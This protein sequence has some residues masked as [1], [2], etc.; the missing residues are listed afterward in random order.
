MHSLKMAALTAITTLGLGAASSVFANPIVNAGF[1]QFP[2]FTGYTTLGNTTIQAGNFHPPVEGALQAL[3]SNGAGDSTGGLNPVTGAQLES[4]LNLTAGT[5]TNAATFKAFTGSAIQQTFTALA[6]Q[7]L[8]LQ[9]DFLTNES[10][11]GRTGRNDTAF[12]TLKNGTNPATLAVLADTNSSLHAT[13]P[14]NDDSNFATSETGYLTY[15]TT[16][17]AGGTYTLGLGVINS[18]DGNVA[19][20]VMVDAIQITGAGGGSVPLPLAL[21][22]APLGAMVAGVA[23][24]R[25]RRGC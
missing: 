18:A 1:E 15:T 2:D 24:K 10:P 22:V 11:A 16:L 19:S 13:N 17:T 4:F 6:G 25:I 9:F 8:T 14:L 12:L 5:L 3:L 7:T 21:L 23:G 20:G